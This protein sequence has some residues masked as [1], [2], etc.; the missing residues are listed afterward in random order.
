VADLGIGVEPEVALG[1]GGR[2][3]AMD[4]SG[5]PL[6]GIVAEQGATAGRIDVDAIGEVT[7]DGVEVQ[8]GIALEAELLGRWCPSD[9]RSMRAMALSEC[10]VGRGATPIQEPELV[11]T[12]SSTSPQFLRTSADNNGQQRTVM[13]R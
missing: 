13:G 9:C 3:L 2:A 4:L 6:L 10:S 12:P 1:L 7:A 8:L 5:P 11:L